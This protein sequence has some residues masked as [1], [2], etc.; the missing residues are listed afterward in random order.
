MRCLAPRLPRLHQLDQPSS[1][2]GHIMQDHEH[3]RLK[4]DPKKHEQKNG[5]NF[6]AGSGKSKPPKKAQDYTTSVSK[7][8]SGRGGKL[9]N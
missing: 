2:K 9:S 4:G 1:A 5:G 6:Y 7:G 3:P 8:R